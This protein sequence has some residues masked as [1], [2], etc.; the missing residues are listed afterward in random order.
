MSLLLKILL[1]AAAVYFFIS[2][3][4]AISFIYFKLREEK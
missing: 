2:F 4:L 1:C 3:V